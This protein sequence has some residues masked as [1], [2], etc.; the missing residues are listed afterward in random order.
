MGQ[1]CP[2]HMH[3]LVLQRPQMKK[4][5]FV[6]AQGC[7]LNISSTRLATVDFGGFSL[8]EEFIVASI[9]SPLLSLG[10]L[11]KHGWSLQKI[12]R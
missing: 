2:W 11:M 9:T 3:E 4:L 8:K 1:R 6:D 12:G 10:K 7:A 5:R